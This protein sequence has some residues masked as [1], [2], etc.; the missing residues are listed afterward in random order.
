MPLPPTLPL[1]RF[2]RHFSG[3]IH[4]D[5]T[6]IARW[7]ESWMWAQNH[8][9]HP[10]PE[11]FLNIGPVHVREPSPPGTPGG[12]HHWKLYMDATLSFRESNREGRNVAGMP[13]DVLTVEV[14]SLGPD[15]C[16]LRF[17]WSFPNYLHML[18]LEFKNE[19]TERWP[20]IK[21]LSSSDRSGSAEPVVSDAA[22]D[23]KRRYQVLLAE[24]LS[25][26][27]RRP[28]LDDFASE[29]GFSA[30]TLKRQLKGLG[31]E[32]KR[33]FSRLLPLE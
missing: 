19:V 26:E 23:L 30:S 7:V 24:H 3:I 14:V 2:P 4:S 5:A 29:M 31:L 25:K 6:S 28:T 12:H 15:R 1:D 32:W 13:R 18:A 27:R 10:G 16:E 33:D 20:E 8:S 11:G 17:G 9:T 21:S 22:S